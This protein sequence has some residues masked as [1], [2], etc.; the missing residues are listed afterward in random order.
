MA[1]SASQITT[2]KTEAKEFLEYSTYTL[3]LVLGVD[4]D[5]VSSSY[6]VPVASDDALYEGHNCL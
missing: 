4:P 2:A 3:C 6:T 5:A 1:L